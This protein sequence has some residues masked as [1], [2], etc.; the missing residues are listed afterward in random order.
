[1]FEKSDQAIADALVLLY[2]LPDDA[3]D[4]IRVAMQRAGLTF[5]DAALHTG[6]ATQG[7]L[8]EAYSWVRR[9]SQRQGRSL[10]EEAL[11]RQSSQ[12]ALTV[13]EGD[14]VVPGQ[15]LLLANQPDSPHSET[16]RTL[17]TELL[18]RTSGRRGAAIFAL[19]SP[20]QQEGRSQLCAELAIAFAQLG[21]RTLLV[22][23]DMRRPRQHVLFG[24]DNDIG[25]AQALVDSNSLR[26]R[27][28]E[29]F[30]NMGLLPSG[31]LPPN[32]LELLSG[33]RFER[34][35]GDWRRSYEFVLVDTPPVGQY[36]D[37]LT[38][39]T[40]AGSVIVLGRRNITSF[41]AM[42]E[43]QRKVENTYA[44]VVGA[45]LNQF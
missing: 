18:M 36:S 44:R 15:A 40:A 32:P 14:R 37:G 43:L 29:G 25:L 35:V 16:V 27:R 23:A 4:S 22:D 28:V 33:P 5:A 24:C 8:D 39:A 2:K 7:E 34:L 31:C 45:V 30:E 21:G 6:I 9:Q 3:M 13:W 20:G 41:S 38:V 17:R 26:I 1:M 42:S 11:H 10:V 19:L 12:R